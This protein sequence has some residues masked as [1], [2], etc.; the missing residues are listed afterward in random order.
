MRSKTTS[1][2]SV[3]LLVCIVH[4]IACALAYA[5]V[6]SQD[7]D[8]QSKPDKL[9][10]VREKQAIKLKGENDQFKLSVQQ[11]HKRAESRIRQ[12][13]KLRGQVQSL[14]K[15]NLKASVKNLAPALN[16]HADRIDLRL[17]EIG[18]AEK[19]YNLLAWQ[20]AAHAK[21]YNA[22]LQDYEAELAELRKTDSAYA[23]HCRD[24]AKHRDHYHIPGIMPPSGSHCPPLQ[25]SEAHMANLS[26]QFKEDQRRVLKEERSLY[27][28]EVKLKETAMKRLELERKL[29]SQ[30]GRQPI[31]DLE[32]TLQSEYMNLA[33]EYRL[34]EAESSR[35]KGLKN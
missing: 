12:V 13:H 35:L 20:F 15:T 4:T 11:F 31:E 7:K 14:Q 18:A 28:A 21:A 5:Q 27:N 9:D 2:L 29:I 22:H 23:S 3:F 10:P 17:K 32:R 1:C 33:R 19:R 6:T 25:L 16:P 24:Y 26:N 30:A 8:R 34:L